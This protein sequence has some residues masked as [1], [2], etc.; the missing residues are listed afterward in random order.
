MRERAEQGL[1]A[2][3]RG[4]VENK[5]GVACLTAACRSECGLF[6]CI[7]SKVLRARAAQGALAE[8]GGDHRRVTSAELNAPGVPRVW[9][10]CVAAV[11][12]VWQQ[13]SY[14]RVKVLTPRCGNFLPFVVLQQTAATV[15]RTAD[16]SV[17]LQGF[18]WFGAC[19]SAGKCGSVCL[20]SGRLEGSV[21]LASCGGL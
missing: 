17:S 20:R 14:A 4:A 2:V 5:D 7:K 11:L 16:I 1:A 21:W 13:C 15:D 8:L 10:Q 12:S 9:R 18:V 6:P 19:F 3:Y